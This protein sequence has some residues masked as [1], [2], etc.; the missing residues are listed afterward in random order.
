[1]L[2]SAQ[3]GGTTTT[4][5]LARSTS[6]SGGSAP[7]SARS[8]RRGSRPSA[9]SATASSSEVERTLVETGCV[10]GDLALELTE[11]AAVSC[12]VLP[13]DTLAKLRALGVRVLLDDFG[14]G[15]SSLNHIR[16][17]PIDTIKIDGSFIREL[18]SKAGGQGDSQSDCRH[19]DGAGAGRRRGGG[20]EQGAG[21]LG[22]GAGLRVRSG[23]PLR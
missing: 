22:L 20:G 23:L 18:R 19:G 14:T 13:S 1:M 6:I 17:L 16:Q 15:Y 12:G 8:T 10:S 9:A 21:A 5:A 11:S 7:S 3:C 4:A 2:C